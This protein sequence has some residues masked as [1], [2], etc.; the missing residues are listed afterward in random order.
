MADG[1][2]AGA[3]TSELGNAGDKAASKFRKAQGAVDLV[4]Q[5]DQG[6]SAVPVLLGEV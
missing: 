2:Q 4:R 6:L 1:Q 3:G 5:F